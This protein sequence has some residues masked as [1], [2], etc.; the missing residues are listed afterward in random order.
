MI[1]L[2]PHIKE[3]KFCNFTTK[4]N[5]RM[6]PIILSLMSSE[7]SWYS[8]MRIILKVSPSALHCIL[9]AYR[10]TSPLS[11]FH[12]PL[13]LSVTASTSVKSSSSVLYRT[14]LYVQ[15][16][17]LFWIRYYIPEMSTY[18][19]RESKGCR[20]TQ[21][22]KWWF[23]LFLQTEFQSFELSTSF[24]SWNISVWSLCKCSVP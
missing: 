22:T 17:S 23:V 1:Q 5:N 13:H 3:N 9:S 6:Y 12:F 2:L 10:I 16:L 15:D 21:G 11:T 14:F 4:K 18:L 24:S 8:R 19:N 7:Y 20:Y